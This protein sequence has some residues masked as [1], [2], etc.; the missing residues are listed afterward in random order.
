MAMHG[1]E[2][3]RYDR[4]GRKLASSKKDRGKMQNERFLSSLAVATLRMRKK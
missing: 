1:M 3:A 4:E 2:V